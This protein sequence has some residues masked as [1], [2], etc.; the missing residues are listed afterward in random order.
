MI[1][2]LT[3]ASGFIGTRLVARLQQLGYT[4]RA[5][6]RRNPGLPSVEFAEWDAL[7]SEPAPE[8]LRDAGAVIHLAGEPVAQRWTPEVKRRI[9]DTRVLGTR[10][11]V[12]ALGRLKSRPAKFISASA[13]GYYG[14][15]GDE[16]LP[17]TAA[18]GKG[19][20]AE[21]CLEWERESR[22]AGMHDIR[23]ALLRVGIVLGP[24]GGALKQLLPPFRAGLGGRIGSGKQW[25][26]WIHVDDVVEMIL[27][28]LQHDH[29][30]G[31]L[32]A[33]APEPVRNAEFAKTLGSVLGRPAVLPTPALALRLA[34]GEMASVILASQ[35]V[36]P[37]TAPKAGFVH[38]YPDLRGA[39]E[40]I[41]A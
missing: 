24:E 29:V 25:M 33:T 12:S 8:S 16:P 39:L 27:F 2:A 22:Q 28:A 41:L 21:V 35:R 30:F 15:R 38:K 10:H 32:N 3:G 19:F 36:V 37:E 11:L 5:L 31:P 40:Q 1:V 6:G 7:R 23:V 20:L 14:D 18:P 13:I 4:V 9:R 26:S 17:E 34:F